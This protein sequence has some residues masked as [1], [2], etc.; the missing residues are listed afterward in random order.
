MN[1]ITKLLSKNLSV[2]KDN[3]PPAL[4]IVLKL[5]CL[6]YP[7]PTHLKLYYIVHNRPQIVHKSDFDYSST[8][9]I[10]H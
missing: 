9:E 2:Y 8:P 4:T 7:S 3:P 5:T 10:T 1:V 6:A